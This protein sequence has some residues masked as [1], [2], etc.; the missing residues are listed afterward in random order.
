MSNTPDNT[1]LSE[2]EL[3]IENRERKT[4]EFDIPDVLGQS[5]QP[6]GKVRMRIATV[7]EQ[8]LAIKE[9]YAYANKM[10]ISDPDLMSNAK[11][12]HILHKVCRNAKSNAPAFSSPKWMLEK[13]SAYELGVL[14]NNYNEMVRAAKK[15]I[16]LEFDSQ[17]LEAFA[18]FC[19]NLSNSKEPNKF[20]QNYN[21]EQIAEIAIRMAILYNE[22]VL[23]PLKEI[24]KAKKWKSILA[25]SIR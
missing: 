23:V 22:K 9:A 12:A 3:A 10:E 7:A 2:L 24:V 14:N 11:A 17:M 19:G 16:D 15:N 4:Y 8:D 21:S 18:Q 1:E 6:I 25:Q 5:G 20:L 13:M